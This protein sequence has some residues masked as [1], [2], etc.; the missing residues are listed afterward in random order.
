M[1]NCNCGSILK[2]GRGKFRDKKVEYKVE[3]N[4]KKVTCII[5]D[6]F[7]G[8]TYIGIAKCGPDDVMDVNVGKDVAYKKA[9][10]KKIKFDINRKKEKIQ[11]Y[12]NEIEDLKRFIEKEYKGIDRMK[13][14]QQFN[15]DVIKGY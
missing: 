5:T 15:N 4:N 12:Q 6:L 7:I 8:K 11:Y 13:S 9:L 14:T 1:C 3:W 10:N 2:S